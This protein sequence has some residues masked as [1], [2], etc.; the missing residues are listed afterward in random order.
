MARV[1]MH[2]FANP[3]RFLQLA[4]PLTPIF[5]WVGLL[6]AFG[7]CWWGLTQV[8]AERL[9]GDTV[10]IMFV[11][12]PAAWLGMAGWTGIAIAS[13]IQLVWRH[14]LAGVSARA[15]AVPGALFAALCLI[16]GSI[17]GKPTWGTWWVWDGRLTS[18]LV[19]FF[20]YLGFIAL[21][22]ASSEK[23]NLS[24]V[25]AVFG[26]IGV[27]NIPII[28]RSVVWWESQHQKASITLGGSA[29]SDVYL[30]PLLISA[31]GFS[32]LFGAIVLMRMRAALAEIRI[33]A[34]MRRM[35]ED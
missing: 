17:W 34:R 13:I 32:F 12:V 35:A 9:Q 27:V 20:L 14:P 31:L 18:M 8:P 1:I 7:A 28:N 15:I 33:E 11:H 25:A 21:A 30:W 24:R 19:L 23:G 29:I 3:A 2:R 16:T 10:K 5:L 26:I 22:N 4:R 6:M